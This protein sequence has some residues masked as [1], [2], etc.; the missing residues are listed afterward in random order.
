MANW[1]QPSA[2]ALIGEAAK[3]INEQGAR[4]HRPIVVWAHLNESSV[5]FSARIKTIPRNLGQ[6]ILSVVPHDIAVIEDT[7]PVVLPAKLF[8]LLHQSA[9]CRY[10]IGSGGRG[11]GKSHAFAT[12]IVLMMITRKLRV[13]CAREIQR[14]LRES[15]HHLLCA[16]I[17]SLGLTTLFDVTDRSIACTATGAEV[18]FSGLW[19]N[20][21]QLKSLENISLAWIEEGETVSRRS[22]EI[23]APTVRASRSEIWISMN[24]DAPDGPV[25]Q[26]IDA[27][28][29]DTR[30]AHVIHADNPFFPA[31]LEQERLYLQSVDVDGY[32]HVWLGEVRRISDA[33]IFAKKFVI[34]EFEPREEWSVYHGCDFGFSVDPSAAVRAYVADRTLY[35]SHEFWGLRVELDSLSNEIQA[36]IP[37]SRQHK[38][39]CD[40]ARPESINYLSRHGHPHAIAAPKWPGSILDGIQFLRSFE[41][42]V[43]H[44]RCIHMLDELRSYSFKIDRLTGQALT[45]PEDRN[46]HLCDA[47]RYALSALIRQSNAGR[48]IFDWYGEE[49]RRVASEAGRPV[50]GAE[51]AAIPSDL[52]VTT[53]LNGGVTTALSPSFG[54]MPLG[55]RRNFR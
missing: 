20:V 8:A 9:R 31:P 49:A 17:D 3:V 40:A 5:N 30:H 55:L 53:R 21:S 47:L 25:Q 48:G 52:T 33:I 46:N 34:E 45:E 2:R 41:R 28:R 18:I 6:R 15:V 36:A 10:R 54:L 26:H 19:A 39:L 7:E 13:L 11:S 14:S 51:N 24:P 43:C 44:P 32:R 27:G 38:L 12:V 22:L 29:S 35:I 16:K 42:I 23:L 4:A 1:L 50:V 37:G